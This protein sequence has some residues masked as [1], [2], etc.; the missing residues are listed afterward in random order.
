MRKRKQ[1][2]IWKDRNLNEIIL[3]IIT[4]ISIIFLIAIFFVVVSKSERIYFIV[5][6]GII[7]LW[8]LESQLL[9]N[10]T[11]IFSNGI[12]IGN[13]SLKRWHTVIP[14]RRK[15]LIWKDITSIRLIDREVKVPGGSWSR[16]FTSIKDKDEKR[17]ECVVYDSKGFI[18]ALKKLNKDHL[19]DKK[20]RYK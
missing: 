13:I 8:A 14:K 5:L 3:M 18:L 19:L 2:V 15:F 10:L 20:S 12:L 6:S 11:I 4:L 1:I 17:Y 16:K 9:R 7:G